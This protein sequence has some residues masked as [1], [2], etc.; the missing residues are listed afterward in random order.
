MQCNLGDLE[1]ETCVKL[2]TKIQDNLQSMSYT[3]I[4]IS[5]LHRV[6]SLVDVL[7][8]SL[9]N[10]K[11]LSFEMLTSF[12]TALEKSSMS[13][14]AGRVTVSTAEIYGCEESNGNVVLKTS[15]VMSSSDVE[16]S[17]RALLNIENHVDKMIRDSNVVTK[18]SSSNIMS[19]CVM[20]WIE[21]E[22]ELNVTDPS[23]RV[24]NEAHEF[25]YNTLT[26]IVGREP[27]NYPVNLNTASSSSNLDVSYVWTQKLIRSTTTD[28]IEVVSSSGPTI[29]RVE[30]HQDE[31]FV[32]GI[33]LNLLSSDAKLLI[34]NVSC[35]SID[36][37][38]PPIEFG[39]HTVIICQE[40]PENVGRVAQISLDDGN[41]LH[42][43]TVLQ[44]NDVYLKPTCM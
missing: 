27:T 20:S 38:N 32:F 8:P 40:I 28:T 36:Q 11:D 1:L 7:I 23:G 13:F 26:S 3:I 22:I 43:G 2:V 4:E 42:H 21:I 44:L 17:Q 31:I 15:F 33:G 25:L 12:R 34:N 37:N 9:T 24:G 6:I 14:G 29:M 18:W 30:K 41:T 19:R 16:L 5:D 39:T 10:C 35:T